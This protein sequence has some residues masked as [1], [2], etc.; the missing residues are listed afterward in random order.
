MESQESNTTVSST[1]RN[2][3]QDNER[4]GSSTSTNIEG[5]SLEDAVGKLLQ[6]KKLSFRFTNINSTFFL[7]FPFYKNLL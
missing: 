7:L 2:D 5:K 4:P 3:N 1:V 6:G